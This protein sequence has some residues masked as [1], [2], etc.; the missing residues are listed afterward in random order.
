MKQK[1]LSLMVLL[2]ASL[3]LAPIHAYA[4]AHRLPADLARADFPDS[5]AI[6]GLVPGDVLNIK[7]TT[8][9]RDADGV[10]GEAEINSVV[11]LLDIKG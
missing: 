7:I 3:W 11:V 4:Q 10:V 9:F 2:A 8:V 6:L 5:G 1:F